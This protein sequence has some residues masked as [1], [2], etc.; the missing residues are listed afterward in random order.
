MAFEFKKATKAAAK[1][2]MVLHGPSGSGKTFSALSIAK[3]L[4]ERVAVIDTE[5]GSASKYADLF[6]FDVCEIF[7]TY[8]PRH[9]IEGLKAAA[10]GHDVVVLDSATHFWHGEGGFLSLVDKEAKRSQANGKKYD[11]FGAWKSVDPLYRELV[12]VM[13]NLPCHLIVCVRAKTEYGRDDKGKI[14]KLGMKPEFREGFEYEMDV[15]GALDIQHNLTISK[16]RINALD[17]EL[18]VKPGK[19]LADKMNAWL[20]SGTAVPRTVPVAIPD[21]PP[22]DLPTGSKNVGIQTSDP[23]SQLAKE[24]PERLT[25][26]VDPL[27]PILALF[28]QGTTESIKEGVAKVTAAKKAG[29]LNDAQLAKATAAYNTAKKALVASMPGV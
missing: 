16:T 11:Q 12:T 5:Q 21:A 24:A 25:P 20:N 3:H 28:A 29:E 9:L 18:F 22:A 23:T 4:G 8:N 2:R 1:L 19:D 15:E 6:D 13:L 26:Q 14:E 7:G 27:E 10:A 17:G